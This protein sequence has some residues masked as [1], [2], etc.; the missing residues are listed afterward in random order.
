MKTKYLYLL[1]LI[2]IL[3]ACNDD[4][5]TD[6]EQLFTLS[7]TALNFDN[8]GGSKSV[9]VL[10]TDNNV[11]VSFVAGDDG[12]CAYE[13]K[14]EGGQNI[15][16]ITVG[17]NL[18][19]TNRNAV[20]QVTQ[21][22]RKLQLIVRQ[23]QKYYTNTPPVLNLTATEGP[24]QV[25]LAWDEPEQ[26]N[27]GHVALSCLKSDGSKVS[28]AVLEKGVT[29]YTFNDL[30]SSD[31]EYTFVVRSFDYENEAGETTSIKARAKKFVSFRFSKAQQEIFVGYYLRSS[32]IVASTA[33][34]GS[35]EFNE[36]E[37]VT[38]SFEIDPSLLDE[39]NTTHNRQIPLMP[40]EAYSIPDMEYTGTVDFQNLSFDVSANLL[41]DRSMYAIPIKIKTVSADIIDE[42]NSRF[43]FIYQVDDF[44]GW[45]T[46]EQL[47][48]SGESAGNYPA[49]ARRYI[50]RTGANTWETGYLFR[51]YAD[52]EEA[53]TTST[54]SFQHITL[55]VET[56]AIHV[57]QGNY[58]TSD[59]RNVFDL[60]TNEFIFEYL[61]TAW[62][63][64]WTHERMYNRGL[65]K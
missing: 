39:Y 23:A 59:D 35:V 41:N 27:F 53:G 52:N 48:K 63:G 7:E 17:E 10:G 37:K 44:A 43:L 31:G 56:K 64:Y 36:N 20:L 24:Q 2:G 19:I 11:S 14:K 50:K 38:I 13:T 40:E 1:L 12:W 32:D 15:I 62:A 51:A 21:D 28:E 3:A 46:V 65:S 55:N 42:A 25:S 5:K 45:Y 16:A 58:E 30:L 6:E 22:G 49:G 34:L 29:S 4:D 60:V 33:L 9:T 8:A 54:N 18:Q 57:R 47:S 61:Y 26:A